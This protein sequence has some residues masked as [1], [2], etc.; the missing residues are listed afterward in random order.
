MVVGVTY[1]WVY[2]KYKFTHNDNLKN[3]HKKR[4]TYEDYRI[5]DKWA[6]SSVHY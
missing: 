6:K 5:D 2:F 1:P 4:I 3:I